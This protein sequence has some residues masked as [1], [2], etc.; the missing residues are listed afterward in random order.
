MT[1]ITSQRLEHRTVTDESQSAVTLGLALKFALRELRGGLSGFYIFLAC[2]ALGVAAISGVN[3]VALSITSGIAEEGRT[4]LGGDIAFTTTQRPLAADERTYVEG[5]G[6]TSSA[7]TMRAMARTIDGSE[8]ALVELKAVNDAWP[9]IGNFTTAPAEAATRLQEENVVVVEPLL[10]TRMG[11]KLGDSLNIGS[12]TAEIIGTI[13]NE[14]DRISDNFALG[15]KLLMGKTTLDASQLVRPGSLLNYTERVAVNNISEDALKALV[16]ETKEKFPDAG[17][18]IRSR[19]NAAPA[20]TRNVDRFSQFLTLVGLTA[21]IVGGVGVANAVRAFLDTKSGVIASF[22]SLGAPAWF[23]FSVYLIQILLLALVGI[24]IG[25]AIGAVMPWI[26]KIALADILPVGNAGGFHPAVLLSAIAYGLLTAL[27][28]ALWP[29]GQARD[30]PATALFRNAS[31]EDAPLPRWPYQVATAIVVLALAGLAVSQAADKRVALTFIGGIAFSFVLLR[32]VASGIQ[33]LA[34]YAPQVKSTPL[35]LAL[36]NIHRPGA[37]TSSVVLSLG[38][39]LALL[40]SLALID[41]NLRN[42]ISSNVPKEA[43]DFFFVDVQQTEFQ[44]FLDTLNQVAPEGKIQTTP[45]LRGRIVSINDVP[46]SEIKPAEGG[47]WVLRGE[48]GVTYNATLPPNA[49][50]AAGEW[51]DENH[52]GE[53]LLSFAAEE[54]REVGVK[55][56]DTVTIN[57]L[58]R[59]ITARVAN[60]RNVEWQSMGINFVMVFSPN[61]F[62]GAPHAHLATLRVDGNST[63]TTTATAEQVARDGEILKT[64]TNRF[65]TVTAVRVRDALTAV[66]GLIEQLGTAIRA[67]A[68]LALAASI[69]VLGG[70]LAAGNRARVHDAVVLKTLGATR[71]TLIGAF[72]L[73]YALLGFAT[74]LFALVAGGVAAWFVISTIMGFTFTLLPVV[75]L[76]T[77]AGALILTVGFGLIGTWRVLGQK[78]APVLRTL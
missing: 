47:R 56:G 9:L 10:L 36:G 75:A 73:E 66:N 29:L 33:W 60:L 72:V 27:A 45:M 61:T 6:A 16:A 40:V 18:R 49:T 70:A 11:L 43:P 54:A 25:L 57:V 32:A 53:N 46:A 31:R 12:A 39:G 48:R 34:R 77:I 63:I 78:A 59:N 52:T 2:I 76:A 67:A 64:I 44:P 4:L 14:P 41:G 20:L 38:L 69:L 51:W 21:L 3:A 68:L 1:D 24:A 19:G 23:T 28:F 22:K 35:R 30:I 71:R 26:A 7:V 8:Q 65:P 62:A 17:W 37:L 50:L 42:Q 74:A 55:I 5:L 13:T 58:G 15:P